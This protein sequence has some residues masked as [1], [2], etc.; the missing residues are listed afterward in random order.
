LKFLTERFELDTLP[1]VRAKVG[2]FSAAL[3]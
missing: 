2:N 1:G 3:Q